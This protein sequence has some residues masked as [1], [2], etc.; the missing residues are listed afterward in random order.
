M[1]VADFVS[2]DIL[3]LLIF[4]MTTFSVG[5]FCQSVKNAEPKPNFNIIHTISKFK[6]LKAHIKT[7][8][9]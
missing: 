2:D 5:T 6:I 4:S 3:F 1:T 7:I 9:C 8:K